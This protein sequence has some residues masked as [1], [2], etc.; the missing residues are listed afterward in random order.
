M[1]QIYSLLVYI[2]LTGFINYILLPLIYNL[3]HSLNTYFSHILTHSAT[4]SVLWLR[5][6]LY[7]TRMYK[8]LSNAVLIR[9]GGGINEFIDNGFYKLLLS[10]KIYNYCYVVIYTCT[11]ILNKIC[12]NQ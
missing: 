6:K 12:L 2:N 5:I 7:Q 11:N 10:A 3:G 9:E 4:E 8:A 1:T